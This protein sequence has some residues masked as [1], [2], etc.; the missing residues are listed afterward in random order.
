MVKVVE[1]DAED[2][3]RRAQWRQ[4]SGLRKVDAGR[5]KQQLMCIREGGLA[6]AQQ[7]I[8]RAGEPGGRG[9]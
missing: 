6:A 2:L 4:V 1:T 5:R 9:R 3:R 7:R 8:E